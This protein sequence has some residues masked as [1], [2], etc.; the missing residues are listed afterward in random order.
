[1]KEEYVGMEGYA[2]F[3]ERYMEGKMQ[4]AFQ[5]VSAVLD[6]ADFAKLD[7]Q[8]VQ[9]TVSEFRDLR[10][11]ILNNNGSVKE[12]YVGMEGY[13][14]FSEKVYGREDAKGFSEC[15]GCAG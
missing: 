5:N 12:E 7:W 3:S 8:A 9:E 1:M 15:V 2:L 6:K 10:N 11:K 4:K 14:L 13:A